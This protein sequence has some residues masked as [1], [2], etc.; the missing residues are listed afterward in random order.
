MNRFEQLLRT[1]NQAPGIADEIE[2]LQLD[3]GMWKDRR[4]NRRA[5]R[6][7]Q[8]T[9][10]QQQCHFMQSILRQVLN[11][12][13]LELSHHDDMLLESI[14]IAAAALLHQGRAFN[15]LTCLRAR[16]CLDVWGGY[17][18]P[19]ISELSQFLR[20]TPNL[21]RLELFRCRRNFIDPRDPLDNRGMAIWLNHL[22]PVA[23]LVAPA[24]GL[25]SAQRFEREVIHRAPIPAFLPTHLSRLL[26]SL[27]T[28]LVQSAAPHD[29]TGALSSLTSF[30]RLKELYL[31]ANAQ[32]QNRNVPADLRP[33]PN[34]T[35]PVTIPAHTRLAFLLPES[36]EH[37]CIFSLDL[38]L[39]SAYMAAYELN[40]LPGAIKSGGF[41][42]S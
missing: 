11:L 21:T 18:G 36:I 33:S 4:E 24:L 7:G 5:Q 3:S 13:V 42:E 23:G 32:F 12:K 9:R 15:N 1:I 25:T 6:G 17:R 16:F 8:L 20:L 39:L 29:G 31:G 41:L 34:T 14:D 37:L 2:V 28:L 30:T 27:S 40:G 10:Q 19:M 38:D 35:R 26:P 22:D